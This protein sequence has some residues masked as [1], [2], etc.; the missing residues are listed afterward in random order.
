MNPGFRIHRS[1]YRTLRLTALAN[2]Y[3]PLS[4][5]LPL[6]SGGGKAPPTPHGCA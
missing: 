2:P 3:P 1:E 5:R 6:F 4:T